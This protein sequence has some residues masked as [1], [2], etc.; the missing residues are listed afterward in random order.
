M[1]FAEVKSVFGFRVQLQN[2]KSGFPIE[3]NLRIK[4]VKFLLQF[5]LWQHMAN[6]HVV[7]AT[8]QF[9]NGSH[10]PYPLFTSSNSMKL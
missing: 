9:P 5:S 3:P 1:D 7:R 10:G 6:S 8:L 4:G 2:P